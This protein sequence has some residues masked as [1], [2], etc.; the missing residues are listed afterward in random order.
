[1]RAGDVKTAFRMGEYSVVLTALQ[2]Q[3]GLTADDLAMLGISLLR[4]SQFAACEEQ[5]E[6]AMALGNQEAA[7]ELGNYLRATGQS[8]R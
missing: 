1:M 8:R 7:V 2:G 3:D 6:M 5:L 4:T